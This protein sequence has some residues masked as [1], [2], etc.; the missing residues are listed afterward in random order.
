MMI[1]DERTRQLLGLEPGNLVPSEVERA[2]VLRRLACGRFV[3][4]ESVFDIW[5]KVPS[6]QCLSAEEF[7]GYLRTRLFER[8]GWVVFDGLVWAPDERYDIEDED[9][10]E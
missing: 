7:V 1:T 10:W 8:R 5:E 2:D 9:E 4:V 6:A 3:V